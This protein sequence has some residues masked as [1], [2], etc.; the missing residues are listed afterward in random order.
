MAIASTKC[1]TRIRGHTVENFRR[2]IAD[3]VNWYRLTAMIEHSAGQWARNEPFML[4][5]AKR[6]WQA[7]QP[8]PSSPIDVDSG[9]CWTKRLFGPAVLCDNYGSLGVIAALL[10]DEFPELNCPLPG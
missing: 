7:K 2:R 3:D 4:S 5:A 10:F 8:R 1:N 6:H 9:N